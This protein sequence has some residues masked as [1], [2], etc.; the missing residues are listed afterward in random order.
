LKAVKLAEKSSDNERKRQDKNLSPDIVH[1]VLSI[2]NKQKIKDSVK[3]KLINNES[4]TATV[5]K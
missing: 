4:I 5:L 3:D 2:R 1:L